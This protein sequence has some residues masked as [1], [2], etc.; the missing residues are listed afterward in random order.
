MKWKRVTAGLVAAL[1][2]VASAA[3]TA[4]AE[5]ID[6]LE[7]FCDMGLLADLELMESGQPDLA[8]VFIASAPTSGVV[9]STGSAHVPGGASAR[10]TGV[11]ISTGATEGL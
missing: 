6:D 4:P 8:G 3:V 1:L 2:S 7:F 5:V 11:K 9:G 10:E